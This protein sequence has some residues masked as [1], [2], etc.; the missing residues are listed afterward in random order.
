M[1][2][3]QKVLRQLEAERRRLD[4]EIAA[5]RT[6]LGSI[7]D[8]ASPQPAKPVPAKPRRRVMNAQERKGREQADEGVLGQAEE[9]EGP[10][11]VHPGE[12]RPLCPY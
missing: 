11:E 3:L 12:V 4:R 1:K 9:D 7:G 8:G 2:T 6:A 5:I 10:A